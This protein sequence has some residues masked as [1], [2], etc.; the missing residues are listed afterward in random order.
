MFDKINIFAYSKSLMKRLS[1]IIL[2]L[3][4]LFLQILPVVYFAKIR[5]VRYQTHLS[6]EAKGISKN[7]MRKFVFSLQ[8]YQHLSFEQH[9]KEFFWKHKKYDV[10]S[11]DI[12]D[13]TVVVSCFF[14]K[15]ETHLYRALQDYSKKQSS[16]TTNFFRVLLQLNYYLDCK[17]YIFFLPQNGIEFRDIWFLYKSPVSLLNSPP[18]KASF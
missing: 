9:R 3:I 14:D 13:S 16:K 6:V 10:L 15:E 4:F 11:I 1:G 17:N 7:V 18:P 5:W 12:H 2:I 8:E